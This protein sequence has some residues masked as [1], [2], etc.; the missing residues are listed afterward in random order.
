METDIKQLSRCTESRNNQSKLCDFIERRDSEAAWHWQVCVEQTILQHCRMNWLSPTMTIY[1]SQRHCLRVI[2]L[3][4]IWV[5]VILDVKIGCTTTARHRQCSLSTMLHRQQYATA[6]ID[7]T[8]V[9][10]ILQNSPLIIRQIRRSRGVKYNKF[11]HFAVF[12]E[13]FRD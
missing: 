12:V 6:E 9:H 11:W 13:N 2:T 5:Y 3:R 7:G 4:H 8:M 10:S 1:H